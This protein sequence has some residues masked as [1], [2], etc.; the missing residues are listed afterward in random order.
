ACAFIDANPNEVEGIVLFASY[1]S[2]GVLGI[3]AHDMSNFTGKVLDMAGSEDNDSNAS[4]CVS[5]YEAFIASDCKTW[6]LVEGMDHGG[7]G[8]YVNADQPVGSIGRDDATGTVRHYLTSWFLS[9]FYD[10]PFAASNLKTTALQPLSTQE[11]DNTCGIISGKSMYSKTQ[12]FNVYPNPAYNIINIECQS[13]NN[14]VEI[15][16]IL[17]SLIY[18]ATNKKAID[19]SSFSEGVYIIRIESNN[20]S[21]TQQFIK[22]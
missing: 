6:V 18:T 13:S 15:Y 5:G 22:K 14:N 20:H 7:F 8:D 12:D 16:N 21:F 4:D 17:G 1:P 10:D 2:P 3:G 9:E 11:F 19:I